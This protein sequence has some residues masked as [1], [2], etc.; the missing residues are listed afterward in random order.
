VCVCKSATALYLYVIKRDFNRS[1]NKS[2]HPNYI[3]SF[4]SRVPPT[5]VSI[6]HNMHIRARSRLNWL[7][8]VAF[9]RFRLRSQVIVYVRKEFRMREFASK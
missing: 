1:A 5:R 8:E 4:S 3:P 6:L 9:L 2:N 7:N